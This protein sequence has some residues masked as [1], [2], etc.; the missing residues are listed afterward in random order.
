MKDATM[1]ENF[2]IPKI[3]GT[4]GL[5]D[6]IFIH[7][8]TGGL[9]TTWTGPGP[10]E[11]AG[12]FW[13]KWISED[14]PSLNVYTLNYPTSLFE[15]WATKEMSLYDR[16]KATLDYLASF[17]FGKRPIGFITHS[18]GGLLAKQIIRTGI[19][20]SDKGWQAI[21]GNCRL[22]VFLATPHTGAS[23][24]TAFT[25][26]APRLGSKYLHLLRSDSSELDQLNAAYRRLAVELNIKTA[27][28][29]E[30]KRT[31]KVAIVVDRASADPGV[32]GTEIVG[33]EADHI[34]ICKP[35]DRTH[36]VYAG[37]HRHIAEF[38]AN[39]AG[40]SVQTKP[41]IETPLQSQ[42][43]SARVFGDHVA[44]QVYVVLPFD[45]ETIFSVPISY[46]IRTSAQRSIKNVYLHVELSDLIYLHKLERSLDK[47]AEAREIS[48]FS[49]KGRH[50][51]IAR[52]L[53]KLKSVSP[54]TR[55]SLQDFIFA[56]D[57]TVYPIDTKVTFKDGKQGTVQSKVLGAWPVSLTLDGDDVLPWVDEVTIHFRKGDIE[58]FV[59]VKREENR[60]IKEMEESGAEKVRPAHAT[61]IGFRK[62]RRRP[63]EGSDLKI[64]DADRDSA[65]GY[66]VRITPRG[67]EPRGKVE[68]L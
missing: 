1:S 10:G 17:G 15:K 37:V 57:P 28:Y 13:P 66:N 51:H 7:G 16:A 54:G 56:K 35:T 52:V 42:E 50:Q 49:D 41:V 65:V 62:F 20:A 38:A 2:A 67:L 24:A 58:D 40:Q 18:L 9:V 43:H 19:E 34:S 61:F 55:F 27:A 21:A 63:V 23:L 8:L 3:G 31:K 29:F 33:I 22:V 44:N 53:F 60:L 5:A 6:L 39:A 46:V 32:V 14:F 4:G 68:G 45:G 47:L 64:I 11:K 48:F 12:N 30:T 26:V 36:E 25:L 59:S